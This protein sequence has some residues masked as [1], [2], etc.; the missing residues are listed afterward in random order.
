MIVAV[1]LDDVL[2]KFW[3]AFVAFYNK[4]N[5]TK[6]RVRDFSSYYIWEVVG[7][8]REEAIKNM[9]DFYAST[10]FAKIPT[11][12]GAQEGIETIRR[13][14][15]LVVVTGRPSYTSLATHTLIEKHFPETF[16]AV[17][18]TNAYIGTM[19]PRS[20]KE[21]CE[22]IRAEVLLEDHIDHAL[23]CAEA[24][25]K[26]IL[27]DQ[28]WNQHAPPHANITRVFSWEEAQKALLQ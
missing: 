24:G 27:F 3:H 20:K 17:Y 28:P 6:F 8:T 9:Q 18:F 16:A 11:I 1:D 23:P 21:V 15:E 5:G 13:E 22:M 2:V 14:H 19:P 25:I 4:K 7:G 10:A 12:P 26:V